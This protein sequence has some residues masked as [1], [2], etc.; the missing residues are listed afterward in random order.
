MDLE[1]LNLSASESNLHFL[2]VNK[3]ESAAVQ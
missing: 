3:I 2:A 1:Q